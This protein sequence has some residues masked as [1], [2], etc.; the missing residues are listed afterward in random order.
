[1]NTTMGLEQP[2]REAPRTYRPEAAGIASGCS[3][4]IRRYEFE[5][6]YWW[7]EDELPDDMTD[8]D[9]DAWFALSWVDGVRV[10]PR[11]RAVLERGPEHG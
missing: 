9:Y 1:M 3:Q 11:P 4:G 6:G 5:I 10:G 7:H 8:A 2:A